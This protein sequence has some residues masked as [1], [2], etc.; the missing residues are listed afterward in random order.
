MNK[1]VLVTKL[2][3]SVYKSAGGG[4]RQEVCGWNIGP[5][6]LIQAVKWLREELRD[7]R[8]AFGNIGMGSSWLEI[9]GQHFSASDFEFGD[10]RLADARQV[11]RHAIH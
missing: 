5:R 4:Q 1:I 2:S 3:D 10:F 8:R 7:N 6:N 9:N 11:I